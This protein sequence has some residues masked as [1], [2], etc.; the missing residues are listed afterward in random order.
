MKIIALYSIK[1]G[2]G[3]TAAC[4][5]LAYL[6]AGGGLHPT[7]LCDLDPQEIVHGPFAQVVRYRGQHKETSLGS[8]AYDFYKICL[9]DHSILAALANTDGMGLYPFMV[10]IVTHELIHIIR[11]SKF[12]QNFE[13]SPREKLAEETR[14]HSRTREILKGISISGMPQVFEFYDHWRVTENNVWK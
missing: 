14:V 11:F 2:V 7:L 10:Y 12:L 3:K 8:S 1:G 4:V 13:A 6:A 9:Q 5:N